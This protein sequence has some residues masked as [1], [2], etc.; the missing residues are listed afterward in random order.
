MN[1]AH[2]TSWPFIAAFNHLLQKE[3]W[4]LQKLRPHAG[5]I[6]QFTFPLLS[7]RIAVQ[8]SG[9]LMQAEDMHRSPSVNLHIPFTTVSAFLSGGKTKAM[10]L[11]RIDGDVEF[12]TTLAYLFEHL[13][14]EVE[15]D[16]ANIIGDAP[17]H[18]LVKATHQAF[19]Q[20]KNLG[21]AALE[22]IVEYST[23][24]ASLLVSSHDQ[25][26]FAAQINTLRDDLAR[27]EKR[28]NNL[29]KP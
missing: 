25:Q 28:I 10:K 1:A 27:L 5:Q 18:T 29:R 21:T 17:A 20:A 7:V 26:T 22:N 8:P 3:S 2:F 19:S 16:L 6:A 13:Q 4:A 12:A 23:Y 11:V 24:E 15:E 9:L 14:W